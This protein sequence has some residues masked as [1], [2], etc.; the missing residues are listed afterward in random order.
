MKKKR[1]V[2]PL[3]SLAVLIV[4]LTIF[5]N[6]FVL[7]VLK[8]K[9]HFPEEYIGENLKM[10]DGQQFKVFRRLKVTTGKNNTGDSTVFKVRFKF[11]NLDIGIN[12]SLS[13][14]PAP[15]LMGM[16]GFQEKFWTC[17]AK[18]GYFQ[19][20]YQWKSKKFAEK[21]P[22]SFIFKLMTKRAAEGT[23]SYEIIPHTDL[24]EY[25]EQ[26]LYPIRKK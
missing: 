26:R 16:E 10:E 2:I 18:T 7:N 21:Y 20:I 23:L 12:K 9:I 3:F 11:K 19:G 17:H 13:L 14:I 15:F 1:I 4:L 24:S 6:R 25:I 22:E 8:G 5:A